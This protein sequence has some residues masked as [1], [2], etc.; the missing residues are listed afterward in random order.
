M[1]KPSRFTVIDEP[2]RC[3]VCGAETPPLGYTARDHCNKC[4]CSLHLD[5]NPGDRLS[6]CGGVLEPVGAEQGK[7]GFKIIYKCKKC[8]VTKKNIAAKDDDNEIII[9]LFGNP[10]S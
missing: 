6:N 3:A 1:L 2:F 10:V 5:E 4:L 9:R 7:K 8:G